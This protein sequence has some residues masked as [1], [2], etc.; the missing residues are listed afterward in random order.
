MI[1]INAAFLSITM[2]TLLALAAYSMAFVRWSLAIVPANHLLTACHIVNFTAQ[3][4]Q[5]GRWGLYAPLLYIH[6]CPPQILIVMQFEQK[7]CTRQAVRKLILF[8]I[9]V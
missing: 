7:V 6:F 5:L 3:S 1:I 8:I 4:I 2:L 9:V